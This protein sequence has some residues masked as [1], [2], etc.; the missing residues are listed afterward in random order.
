MTIDA[1]YF[2]VVNATSTDLAKLNSALAYLQTSAAGR[3]QL[4]A[5]LAANVT[6][7]INHEAIDDYQAIGTPGDANFGG[8]I[9]WDPD[10]AEALADTTGQ[11]TGDLQSAAMQLMHEVD[12]ANDPSY[13]ANHEQ[14]D[15]QYENAAE[16]Y[17]IEESNTVASQL[18]EA[19][20]DSHYG[21]QVETDGPTVS[22]NSETGMGDA[23][24]QYDNG[25]ET[26]GSGGGGGGGGP[27]GGDDPGDGDPDPGD[28]EEQ[29][30]KSAP[31]GLQ[32]MTAGFEKK[33]K[34][35]AGIDM[36]KGQGLVHGSAASTSTQLIHALASFS[37]SAGTVGHA[38]NENFDRLHP[39]LAVSSA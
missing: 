13:F 2:N 26:G 7:S 37:P 6:I 34:A 24:W 4:D 32:G 31:V 27:T 15:S 8:T 11:F 38:A 30:S 21:V 20:R 17:A 28:D 25:D 14:S 35:D 18:G 19:T 1:S 33:Q 22:Y 9:R 3:E 36:A 16:R 5:A 29:N 10:A 39:L 12:H 23:T